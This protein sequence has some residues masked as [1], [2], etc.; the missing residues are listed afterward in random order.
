MRKQAILSIINSMYINVNSRVK[1]C[2]IMVSSFLFDVG[3][4]ISELTTAVRK[5]G[6]YQEGG[7]SYSHSVTPRSLRVHALIIVRCIYTAHFSKTT[8]AVQFD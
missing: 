5:N 7:V 2:C 8:D 3:G 4:E 6:S 1:F